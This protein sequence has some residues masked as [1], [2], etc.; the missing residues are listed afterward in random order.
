MACS[1]TQVCV[2]SLD[3]V[4]CADLDD[5]FKEDSE[6]QQIKRLIGK[7]IDLKMD[8]DSKLHCATSDESIVALIFGSQSVLLELDESK[9]ERLTN[10]SGDA[11]FQY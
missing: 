6:T 2:F 7:N 9:Y 1:N 5:Q 4:E 10:S 8:F 11:E 3:E